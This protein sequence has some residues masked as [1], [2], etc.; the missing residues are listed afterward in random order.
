MQRKKLINKAENCACPTGVQ[1]KNTCPPQLNPEF[2]IKDLERGS[3][4]MK[5]DSGSESMEDK[6]GSGQT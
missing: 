3:T 6:R 5:K 2:V 1:Q 4:A